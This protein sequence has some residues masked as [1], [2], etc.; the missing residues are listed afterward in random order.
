[1]NYK[2]IYS[3]FVEKYKNQEFEKGQY[4]E[5]HHIL[6]RHA[7]GDDSKENL[8][9]LTYR[10]H[11]F[12]HRLLWKA[13]GKSSDLHAWL[14]MSGQEEDRVVAQRKANG[15]AN[16]RSGHLDRIREKIDWEKVSRMTIE[17]NRIS[18]EK[19][20]LR[21]YCLQMNEM[22]RGCKHADEW[23]A[24]KSRQGKI[25][26]SD[27]EIYKTQMTYLQSG[28]DSRKQKSEQTSKDLIE[29]AERNEEYLQK[30]TSKSKNKFISPEG[31]EFDSPIYAAKYYGNIKPHVIENWCKRNQN[32][33]SRKPKADKD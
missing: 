21:K 11:T 5:L 29:N 3:A 20:L 33:W 22:W 13:F 10:Q 27:S 28:R 26:M 19:G 12:A 18:A 7:G 6:P 14:M 17:R 32:G 31:L 1:M 9:R 15:L 4:T 25:R 24:E 8:I 2:K 23:K 16:V 30:T